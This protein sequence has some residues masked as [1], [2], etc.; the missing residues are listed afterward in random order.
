M[1]LRIGLD[2]HEDHP[3]LRILA[4]PEGIG[5]TIRISHG[6]GEFDF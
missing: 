4:S 5:P 2:V 6:N 1:E 3:V